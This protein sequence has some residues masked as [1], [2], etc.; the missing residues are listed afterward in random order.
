[1]TITDLDF[2]PFLLRRGLTSSL[3]HYS[4]EWLGTASNYACLRGARGP[5]ER[6]LIHLF[7]RLWTTG[8]YILAC[9]VARALLWGSH[10]A[11]V[12]S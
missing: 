4:T 7:Q 1:M 5:S 6:A 10:L 12:A 8:R 9:R 3:R 2:Y 11:E